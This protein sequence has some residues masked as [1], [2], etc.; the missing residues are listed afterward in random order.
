MNIPPDAIE[1]PATL[2]L[3]ILALLAYVFGILPRRN[4]NALLGMQRDLVRAQMAV[5][6]LEKVVCGGTQ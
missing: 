4:R 3:A 1:I 6:E 2:A 5:S